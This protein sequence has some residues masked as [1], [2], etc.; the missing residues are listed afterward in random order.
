MRTDEPSIERFRE[1]QEQRHMG[2]A[3]ALDEIRAGRK[4]GHWIW[5][6]F[7]QIA[8]LGTSAMAQA[9]GIRG[10]EEAAAYL[11]DPVL[12]PRLLAV[13]EAAVE[14]LRNGTPLSTL[15]G[16]DL[17]ATKLVSSMTLFGRVAGGLRSEDPAVAGRLAALAE[18][19]LRHAEA[20]GY[21]PCGSTLASLGSQDGF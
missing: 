3:A 20:Q 9:Y 18:E 16:S 4:H 2:F 19:L 13:T 7:P 14:H 15:M 11:R 1:A 21:P 10:V 6:V 8:G 5:Y 17:D 12:G